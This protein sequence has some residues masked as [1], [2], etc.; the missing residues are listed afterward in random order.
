MRKREKTRVQMEERSKKRSGNGKRRG[1]SGER[2]D[3]EVGV[4]TNTKFDFVGLMK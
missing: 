2:R 3:Q 4:M 1:D